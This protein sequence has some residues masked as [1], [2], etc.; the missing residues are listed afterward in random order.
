MLLK[1]YRIITVIVA[2]LMVPAVA[3]S[4][5]KFGPSA[6][7][8]GA[9]NTVIVPL[10]I[11][12]DDGVMAIDIPLKFSEG[13][14]LK[15]VTFENTRVEHFD[16]KVSRIDNEAHTVVIGLIHQLSTTPKEPLSAGEGRV[17]NLVFEVDDPSVTEIRLEENETESPSHDLVFVYNTRSEPGQLAFDESH[18][19]FE[20]ISVA[21]SGAIDNL[22]TEYA[23]AQN[24]PNPFNPTTE[25]HYDL[26]KAGR[27]ELAVFNI[28]GQQ[29]T[30]LVSGEMPAGKHQVTWD[31]TDSDGGS[32]ASG[33]YFYRISTGSFS[34]SK[35]MM[36]LK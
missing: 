25:I 36:L 34:E 21:L 15:E 20:P 3:F 14:T 27:V 26:P 8:A 12:N 4:A 6:A 1:N 31:G 16:L 35:K 28:L 22:P 24:Y 29:V 10:E 19:D 11:A 2:M 18:L 30:S 9:D 7:V 17:A 23:L 33:I 13:V 5:N 32:V